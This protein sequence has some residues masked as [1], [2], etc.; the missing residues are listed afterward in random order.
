M[1][2][3]VTLQV[4]SDALGKSGQVEGRV[5]YINPKLDAASRT[6]KVKVSVPTLNGTI[7]PGMLAQAKFSF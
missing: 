4:E 5:I 2:Q 6:L 1:D 3:K 7:R